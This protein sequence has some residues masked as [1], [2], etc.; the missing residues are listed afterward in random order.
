MTCIKYICISVLL[1][2]HSQADDLREFSFTTYGQYPMRDVEYSPIGEEALKNGEE[3]VP[4][5][6]IKT[7]V[8]SRVGPYTYKGGNQVTFKEKQ[9][10]K[11]VATVSVPEGSDR[12][13]FV[14][15]RNPNYNEDN[16]TN[17]YLVYPFD[18]SKR[19]LPSNALIF[20]NFSGKKLDGLLEKRRVSFGPGESDSYRVQE[21]LPVNLWTRDYA[22]EKL[23]PALIKTYKF[24]EDFR[25]LMIFFPP[26]LTGS[27]DLDVRL[28]SELVKP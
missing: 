6:E 4:R 27:I 21:S 14:F 26:A 12:W 7:H 2:A 3:P 19:N 1:L 8:L 5:V 16:S 28:L 15:L 10:S 24:K 9:M 23:L 20:L 11:V 13:L 18:D 17:K 22:G 25:Y